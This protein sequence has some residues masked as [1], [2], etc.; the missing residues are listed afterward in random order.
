MDDGDKMQKF[1]ED[2]ITR[3]RM[4]KAM[5]FDKTYKKE[6]IDR[7]YGNYDKYLK[8]TV[9]EQRDDT[10]GDNSEDRFL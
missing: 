7:E 8:N 6:F 9:V 1:T 10:L 2:A 3:T 4:G 5:A